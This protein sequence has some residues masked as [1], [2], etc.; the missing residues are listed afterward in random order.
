MGGLKMLDVFLAGAWLLS[1]VVCVENFDA[2][3]PCWV[4]RPP[5]HNGNLPI[6][7]KVDKM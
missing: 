4:M 6:L 5:R 1:L 7:Y 2:S 3:K